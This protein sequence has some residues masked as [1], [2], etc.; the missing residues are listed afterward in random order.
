MTFSWKFS[1]IFDVKMRKAFRA[2]QDEQNEVSHNKIRDTKKFEN[3][4]LKMQI[5]FEEVLPPDVLLF[6]GTQNSSNFSILWAL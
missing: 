2:H 6:V 3:F 5:S 1:C 4:T